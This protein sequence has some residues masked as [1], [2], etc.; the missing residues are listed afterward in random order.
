MKGSSKE[1]YTFS[2]ILYNS[3]YLWVYFK[4]IFLNRIVQSKLIIIYN[5]IIIIWNMYLRTIIFVNL[6]L[7]LYIRQRF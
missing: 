5:Y 4:F 7:Y 3:H 2:F 6:Y 1:A